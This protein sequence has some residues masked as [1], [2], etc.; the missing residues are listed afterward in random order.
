M[1]LYV[2]IIDACHLRCPTCA[3][4]VRAFPNTA[5]K[6]SLETFE[7]IVL[8][9][10]ADG[11]YRVDLFSWMEPFLCRNLHEYLKIVKD[12]GLP[13][14][15]SSTLALPNIRHFE[16][17][18]RLADLLTISISGA[19]QDVYQINH[20]GGQLDWV[21][22]NLARLGALKAR[23]DIPLNATLRMLMFDY[24][25]G[26]EAPLRA[27]AAEHG[28]RFEVLMAEGHPLRSQQDPNS[29][30]KVAAK[31]QQAHRDG[32]VERPGTVCPLIF[33]HVTLNADGDVYQCTA[34]GNYE[35]L[36]VGNFLEMS[37]EET[38]MR[39]Y[40]QPFCNT[41]SWER[42]SVTPLEKVLFQQAMAARMNEEIV[43]RVPALSRPN[44]IVPT[45]ESGYILQKSQQGAFVRD[46]R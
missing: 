11:A 21:R 5:A 20:V 3:R 23:E 15:L 29:G 35:T 1:L 33:E 24:N 46:A 16:E 43:N 25:R 12:A 13:C 45:T 39:R 28:I 7:R 18:L 4:G 41:C 34:Q 44:E 2:D 40:T 37:R 26:H 42:R 36:K 9:A 30:T 17:A 14:G 8:K 31:L 10:K 32:T 22:A 38:L 19:T 6:M 27:L